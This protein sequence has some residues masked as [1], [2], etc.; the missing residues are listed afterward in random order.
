MMS[1]V[2]DPSVALTLTGSRG[3][4]VK[5]VPDAIKTQSPSCSHEKEILARWLLWPRED[6]MN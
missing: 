3:V 4:G 2:L 6:G 5:P 1:D